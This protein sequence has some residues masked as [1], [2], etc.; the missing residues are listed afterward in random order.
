MVGKVLRKALPKIISKANYVYDHTTSGKIFYWIS[1]NHKGHYILGMWVSNSLGV[2]LVDLPM[3]HE[4]KLDEVFEVI[5]A[6]RKNLE[7][8]VMFNSH[9]ADNEVRRILNAFPDAKSDSIY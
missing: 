4:M 1:R 2:H 5:I 6:L 7:Y 9:L 8:P 3:P